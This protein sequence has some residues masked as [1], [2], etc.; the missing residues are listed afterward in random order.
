MDFWVYILIL[1]ILF[2][3]C[4]Y[5]SLSKTPSLKRTLMRLGAII[6][7][8]ILTTVSYYFYNLLIHTKNCN[9]SVDVFYSNNETLCYGPMNMNSSLLSKKNINIQSFKII[10]NN[11]AFF[12][13]TDGGI[14]ELDYINGAGIT[15]HQVQ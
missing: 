1:L 5:Q 6:I 7:F 10:D 12:N 9:S 8:L 15:M 3:G 4:V 14:Y 13:T 11:R 2:C